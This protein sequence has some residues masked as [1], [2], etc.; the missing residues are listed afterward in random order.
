[1]LASLR[2]DTLAT[3]WAVGAVRV[4]STWPVRRYDSVVSSKITQLVVLAAV[5]LVAAACSS[6][7]NSTGIIGEPTFT[8]TTDG[9]GDFIVGD[10]FDLV[11]TELEAR[12]GGTDVDS[13]E[14][15]TDVFVPACAGDVTRLVSWGNLIVLFTGEADDLRLATWTYGFDPVTG[16]SEDVRQLNLKTDKGIGLGSTRQDIEAAYGSQATFT[17]SE[18]AG[19]EY[20]EISDAGQGRLVGRLS[21]NLTLLELAPTC[22]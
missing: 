3:G 16:S 17:A 6:S 20:L 9:I 8:L 19:G 10:P 13:F 1:V 14:E 15:T 5:C 18:A 7:D 4:G 2:G 11:S 21:P 12:F 22:G